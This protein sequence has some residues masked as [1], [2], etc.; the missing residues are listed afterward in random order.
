M[1]LS[2]YWLK[3]KDGLEPSFFSDKKG[4]RRI[5]KSYVVEKFI[6]SSIKSISL[7]ME[8]T[9]RDQF[10]D[11]LAIEYKKSLDQ[12]LYKKREK[13]RYILETTITPFLKKAEEIEKK[14]ISELSEDDPITNRFRFIILFIN[15]LYGAIKANI[16]KGIVIDPDD[17]SQEG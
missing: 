3:K 14:L 9:T 1:L 15:N 13:Y 10:I 8:R 16:E 6:L 7:D 17:I 5:R 4:E 11:K 12:I 2:F